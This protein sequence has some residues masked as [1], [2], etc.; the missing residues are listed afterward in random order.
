MSK[1]TASVVGTVSNQCAH[2]N[3]DHMQGYEEEKLKDL[4]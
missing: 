1:L 2:A 4:G 3:L